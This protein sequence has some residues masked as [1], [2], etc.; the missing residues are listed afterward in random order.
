MA[1]IDS[2]PENPR[3]IVAC[4]PDEQSGSGTT[5][6]IIGSDFPREETEKILDIMKTQIFFS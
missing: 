5:A 1:T 4:S 2:D 3:Y 6:C